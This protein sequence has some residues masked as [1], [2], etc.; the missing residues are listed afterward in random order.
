[1]PILLR[2]SAE[3][4]PSHFWNNKWISNQI[5]SNV[6]SSLGYYSIAANDVVLSVSLS[7]GI[8][9]RPCGSVA[10]STLSLKGHLL[11]P[12]WC[13]QCV[14]RVHFCKFP[15]CISF[16]LVGVPLPGMILLDARRNVTGSS[17][18]TPPRR[19]THNATS[20]RSVC[21]HPLCHGHSCHVQRQSS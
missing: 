15:H 17:S 12:Y 6:K 21:S 16:C 9:R 7:H 20:N 10:V 8:M 1:M 19:A 3:A 14:Q 4:E 13:G 2:A 5:S 18:P 11:W